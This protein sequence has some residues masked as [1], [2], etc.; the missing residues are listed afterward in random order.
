MRIEE[1]GP[2]SGAGEP[3]TPLD[4]G[5][6]ACDEAARSEQET[7]FADRVHNAYDMGFKSARVKHPR[8]KR[9]PSVTQ[10]RDRGVILAAA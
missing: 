10:A 2:G 6:T 7:S 1:T 5:Q 8:P 9:D 3:A 4:P